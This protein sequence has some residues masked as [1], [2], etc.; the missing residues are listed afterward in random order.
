M[1]NGNITLLLAHYNNPR[2]DMSLLS[3][4]L[5]WFQVNKS[6]F[7]LQKYMGTAQLLFV[8]DHDQKSRDRN[9]LCM[10]NRK[11]YNIRPNEAFTLEVTSVT[12]L[13]E[14]ALSWSGHDR[15]YV[16]RIPGFF[17]RFFLSSSTKCST[18]VTWLL[19]VTEGHVTPTFFLVVLQNLVQ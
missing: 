14:E 12:W 8:V 15:K 13:P 18:V 6:L 7:L 1:Q 3:D 11:L 5:S 10:R 9:V 16:L 19:N 4:I 2:E 17:P